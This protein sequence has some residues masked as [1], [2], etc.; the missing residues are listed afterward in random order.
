MEKRNLF[1]KMFGSKKPEPANSKMFEL[2][3]SSNNSFYP[4]NGKLFDNDIVR[5]CIRPKA[6][7]VGKLNAKHIRG[8]GEDMKINPDPYIRA[9]FQQP[10]PYMSMQDFLTKMTFQ[11]EINHNAFAFIKRDDFGYPLEIYPIPYSV[12]ELK[13]VG[14]EL[15]VKFMFWTGKY[16]AIPYTDIIHLRKDFNND[17]FF[18]EKG[19][20][21]IKNIMEVISTTDQGIINAVKNSAIV[22]WIMMFK[23][24]LQPKDKELAV[25]DFTENYLAIEKASGVAVSDPRYEL[26]QV[27]EKNYV[28]NAFQMDKSIQRLYSYFGVNDAIVQNK[29]KE[30]EWNAFYESEIEPII[31]QLSNAFTRAFFTAREKGLGNKIIFEASNLAYASM[32]TKLNLMQMVDRGAM[33]PNEWRRIMN[34]GPVE[35]GD[36]P[37]RRLDTAVVDK[38][39]EPV[40]KEE[41]NNGNK[42]N[43]E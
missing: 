24:I 21:A 20:L 23:S 7:A 27:E 39:T 33:T 8:Y 1:Q 40:K 15:W 16:M 5:S 13:E 22:K 34:M 14:G 17:D 26:K 30:D 12:V 3:S 35:G 41:N 2:V 36:K 31:I 43:K 11:R 4:W 25:K 38:T 42:N 32:K 9:V 10:N 29:Y 18:G 37:I 6:N 28:P 19:T